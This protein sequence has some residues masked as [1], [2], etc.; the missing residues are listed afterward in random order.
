M[1]SSAEKAT[2]RPPRRLLFE[3][4]ERLQTRIRRCCRGTSV[5]FQTSFKTSSTIFS[6]NVFDVKMLII[7]FVTRYSN[8]SLHPSIFLVS[9]MYVCMFVCLCLVM[10]RTSEFH[11]KFV[12]E[13]FFFNFC[14]K[15][16]SVINLVC[17]IGFPDLKNIGKDTK[18]MSIGARG[19][20]IWAK[21]CFAAYAGGHFEF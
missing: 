7:S 1:D 18:I 10:Y 13:F 16:S 6:S 14:M 2:E 19:A 20:E 17:L 9:N 12:K 3:K 4:M 5:F 21:I 15:T 8:Y 11:I